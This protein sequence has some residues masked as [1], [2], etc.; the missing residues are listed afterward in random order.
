MQKILI[1]GAS[2][3]IGINLV[4]SLDVQFFNVS[5]F[6]RKNGFD[7]NLIDCNYLNDEGITSIVH[8]A[9]KAHDLKNISNVQDYFNVNTDLTIRIFNAFL[10]SNATKFIFFS[11]VKSV[12]D[13]LDGILTEETIPTPTTP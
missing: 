2:G 7:Y 6:S 12:K 1:T 5:P 13:H 10:K 9:G 3:F 4:N 8:L 11:S